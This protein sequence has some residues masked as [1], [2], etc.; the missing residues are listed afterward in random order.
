VRNQH[1]ICTL[2]HLLLIAHAPY[3]SAPGRSLVD[4]RWANDSHRAS[5]STSDRLGHAAQ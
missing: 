1:F 3:V 4:D 2:A 5:G